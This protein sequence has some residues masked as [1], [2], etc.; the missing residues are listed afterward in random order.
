[1]TLTP[2]TFSKPTFNGVQID[3]ASDKYAATILL[4][5][6]SL[7]VA[8][9]TSQL[10]APMPLAYLASRNLSTRDFIE[11]GATLV[12]ARNPIPALICLAGYDSRNP[13]SQSSTP[14][15][16][17]AIVLSDDSPADGEAQRFSHDT[18]N[19]AEF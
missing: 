8:L 5:V 18:H 1:M 19:R 4:L 7:F 6:V 13:N 9:R 16:A 2:M 15:T 14:L 17:I 3:F 11:L 12:N 10:P